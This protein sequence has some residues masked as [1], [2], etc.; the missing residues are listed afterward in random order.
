MHV[1]DVAHREAHRR[2][3]ERCVA[4]R[5]PGHVALEEARP[6]RRVGAPS[7]SARSVEHRRGEVD[8]GHPQRRI[9][10]QEVKDQVARSAAQVDDAAAG[11]RGELGDGTLTPRFVDARSEQPIGAV[12]PRGDRREHL[13]DI[14][15]LIHRQSRPG[16][17]GGRALIHSGLPPVRAR[18]KDRR[19]RPLRPA[20]GS[21]R[22]RPGRLRLA[23][24]LHPA[25]KRH[26]PARRRRPPRRARRACLGA[27]SHRRYP[28]RAPGPGPR[29]P[30][31]RR[32][33]PPG[34]WPR[35]AWSLHA[36]PST[37]RRR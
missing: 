23:V 14:E 1:D 28:R 27:L 29:E 34:R 4:E 26:Q 13:A 10:P 17:F 35:D 33:G 12:V 16:L 2:A 20:G 32:H 7:A 3:V 36:I 21:C 5:Q 24:G 8:A 9:A 15:C 22:R 30:R 31:G 37:S 11:G 19:D 25:R 18:V 6:L